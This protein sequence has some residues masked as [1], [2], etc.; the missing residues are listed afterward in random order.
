MPASLVAYESF[1]VL[2]MDLN[3]LSSMVLVFVVAAVIIGIGGTVLTSVQ[4]TQ[5][6]NG[7][8]YN[9]T[10][11]GLSGITTFGEWLP[12]I[13]VIVAAAI[14]IGIIVSMFK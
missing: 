3:Q 13:A 4:G 7:I 12:T 10:G 2:K 9:A 14:V 1:L 11:E 5:T 6:A 8:A